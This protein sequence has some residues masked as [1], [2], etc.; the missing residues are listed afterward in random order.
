MRN[1]NGFLSFEI[2]PFAFWKALACPLHGRVLTLPTSE[3]ISRELDSHPNWPLERPHLP[4]IW[5]L[6][7]F[8]YCIKYGDIV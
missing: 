7:E 5:I 2:F 1:E 8:C 6:M 3:P 4:I